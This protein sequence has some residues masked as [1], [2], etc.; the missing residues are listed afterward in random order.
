MTYDD[1]LVTPFTGFYFSCWSSLIEDREQEEKEW[2]VDNYDLDHDFVFNRLE[3]DWNWIQN[4]RKQIC[5]WYAERYFELVA[6]FTGI[7]FTVEFTK[8]S[9]PSAYNY[10][11]DQLLVTINTKLSHKQVLKKLRALMMKHY[12]ELKPIIH[13]CHSSRDGFISFMSS[14]IDEWYDNIDKDISARPYFDYVIGYLTHIGAMKER[15]ARNMDDRNLLDW[16]IYEA[17]TFDNFLDAPTMVSV[18]KEDAEK[19]DTIQDEIKEIDRKR[20][21]DRTY[22]VIPG[23]FD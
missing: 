3:A 18:W 23:L 7:E 8:L 20:H 19:W 22:P 5:E 4:S 21:Q 14:D 15:W 9:S 12:D 13:D 6:D 2:L 10:A 16:A 1:I 11:N 17:V